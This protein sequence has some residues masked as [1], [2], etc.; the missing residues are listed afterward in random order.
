M[1]V[2]VGGGWRARGRKRREGGKG[3]DDAWEGLEREGKIT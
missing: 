1:C 2:W 3:R